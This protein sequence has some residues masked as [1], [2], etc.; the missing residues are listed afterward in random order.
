M[1]KKRS[2]KSSKKSKMPAKPRVIIKLDPDRSIDQILGIPKGVI[3]EI[4]Q[5]VDPADGFTGTET[6]E[7]GDEYLLEWWE[8]T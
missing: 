7:E 8:V 4:R 1:A 6:D 5:Y 2:K 3:V